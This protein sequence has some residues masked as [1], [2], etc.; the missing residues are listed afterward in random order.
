[1]P[2][3]SASGRLL[4]PL[5]MVLKESTGTF[6][7]RVQET[8]FRPVNIYIQASTS[9][10]FTSEHFKIW[11]SDVYLPNTGRKSM[12]LL[13]SWTGHCPSQLQQ[14]ILQDKKIQLLTI[15][16]KTTGLIQPLDVFGFR[17]W[18][19]FVRTF[20]DNIIFQ[21]KDVNLHSRNEIIKLHTLISFLRLDSTIFSN[22]LGLKAYM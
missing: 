18:K 8:L 21:E 6:G 3:I 16:K 9:G 4:S 22:M 20:S 19:N 15:P 5:Y 11:F 7:P 13:D 2:I 12:L 1:M 14:L 17:I 10:K